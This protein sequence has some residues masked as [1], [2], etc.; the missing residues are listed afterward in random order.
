MDR[1]AAALDFLQQYDPHRLAGLRRD[2]DGIF[3]FLTAGALAEWESG[4]RLVVLDERHVLDPQTSA[5]RLASTLVHEATHARLDR[6]GF[7][8][9]AERRARIEGICFRRE[10]AF[11]R[12]LP[13]PGD[14]VPTA[15][16]QLTREPE[17]W[18][19]QAFR[20][21]T[22]AELE[23]LGV[24][25]WLVRILERMSRRWAA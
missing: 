5:A 9:A 20:E 14:L 17:Y 7:R 25:S 12:R 13:E 4:A 19:D 23:R 8:Y 10:I 16:R 24:P 1:V 2:A 6:L 11:A 3:V 21:R 18:T 22:A 15:E